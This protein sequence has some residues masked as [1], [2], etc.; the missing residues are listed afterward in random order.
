[1]DILKDASFPKAMREIK[2]AFSWFPWKPYIELCGA[3]LARLRFSNSYA[4]RKC[5]LSHL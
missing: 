3:I 5:I 4:S 1:M 2:Y